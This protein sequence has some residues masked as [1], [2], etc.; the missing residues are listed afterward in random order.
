M[1][2]SEAQEHV[3]GR[4]HTLFV[5]PYAAFDNEVMERQLHLVLALKALL[6]APL[7]DGRLRLQVLHG[8]E[9]GNAEPADLKHNDYLINTV[10]DLQLIAERYQQ[11][12]EQEQDLA[13]DAAPLLAAPLE[14]AIATAEQQGQVIPSETQAN[15]AQ[16]PAFDTG[17]TLYTLF[18]LYHRL[19]YGEDET[20]RS[21]RCKTA[22]GPREIHEFHLEEGEFAILTPPADAAPDIVMLI[23]HESQLRPVHQLME[24]C[25]AAARKMGLAN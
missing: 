4:L 25:L 1:S 21:S 11:A 19:T 22:D 14:Q 5:E 13:A 6:E 9:N 7:N 17:L 24:E 10:S 18:K 15:P 12:I 2:Y 20:Y 23:L 16:W 3:T 8:W